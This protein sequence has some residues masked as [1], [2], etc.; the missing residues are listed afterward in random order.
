M[1]KRR[2]RYWSSLSNTLNEL[3]NYLNGSKVLPTPRE[4]QQAG[5]QDLA[6]ALRRHGWSHVSAV[7]GIPLAS[8]AR[9]RSLYLVACTPSPP[10]RM[11]PYRYWRDFRNLEHELR[12]LVRNNGLPSASQL[13]QAK[14]GY[15]VRA[16][17]IH[18]GWKA[19]AHR[20]GVRP[21]SKPDW[22]DISVVQ[23]EIRRAMQ[24]ANLDDTHS[25]SIHIVRKFGARGL[26]HAIRSRHGGM[27]AVVDGMQQSTKK[28]QKRNRCWN[29]QR[30]RQQVMSCA[31]AISETDQPIDM[32]TAAQLR[33]LGRTD[34]IYAISK[35]GG[36][37]QVA[38]ACGLLSKRITRSYRAGSHS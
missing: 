3:T 14:R 15:I 33:M 32:P 37:L 31:K 5:R 30:L 35:A 1:R 21:S 34:V 24:R 25:P 10:L 18:G 23:Q 29:E 26:T 8:V 20:M 11:R 7:T 38:K 17:R 36:F 12:P 16:I 13:V 28:Y 9:P 19:V 6:A 4:L 22:S 2:Y 27:T